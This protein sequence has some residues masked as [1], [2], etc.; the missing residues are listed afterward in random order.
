MYIL[1]VAKEEIKIETIHEIY[2]QCMC[3]LIYKMYEL[4]KELV[5][6]N[7]LILALWGPLGTSGLQNCKIINLWGFL[8][9]LTLWKFVTATVG[10]RDKGIF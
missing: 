2:K 7:T 9:P 10:E 6:V 5:L 3:N 1:V 8:K 4:I